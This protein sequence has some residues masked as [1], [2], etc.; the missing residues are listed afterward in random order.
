V[1]E[2]TKVVAP[3]KELPSALQAL[4][5]LGA[6]V[7]G[8]V[9]GPISLNGKGLLYDWL[10]PLAGYMPRRYE[11]LAGTVAWVVENVWSSV[12]G[13][14]LGLYLALA[15]RARLDQRSEAVRAG[16]QLLRYLVW[17]LVAMWGYFAFGAWFEIRA[18][19]I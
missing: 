13:A 14:V 18:W 17:L 11:G 8:V 16:Y 2:G 19:P 6:V 10:W 7:A 3:I 5:V 9:A 12:A 1:A 4:L 15:F